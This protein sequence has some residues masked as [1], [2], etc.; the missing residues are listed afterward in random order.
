VDDVFLKLHQIATASDVRPDPGGLFSCSKI[1]AQM[2]A[3]NVRRSKDLRELLAH[4]DY[5]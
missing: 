2:P 1:S 5:L 4:R 3:D